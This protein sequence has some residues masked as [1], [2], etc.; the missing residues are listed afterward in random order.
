MTLLSKTPGLARV[1][2]DRLTDKTHA[3]MAHFS[4][5]GPDGA[6]CDDCVFFRHNKK[7]SKASLFGRP[8]AGRCAK[9][10]E[11]MGEQGKEFPA[12]APA[13]RYYGARS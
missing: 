11:L 1:E 13:C 3:G 12:T 2:I 7:R 10:A 4:G 6:C 9:H 8:L 5:T